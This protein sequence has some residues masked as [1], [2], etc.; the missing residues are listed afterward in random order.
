MDLSAHHSVQEFFHDAVSSA[1]RNQSLDATAL[2]EFYLVNLLSEYAKS[3]LSDA[4]LALRLSEAVT[5]LP[6]ERA[7]KLREIGDQSL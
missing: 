5:A 4:P 2:T 3:P 6:E 1:M 7:H